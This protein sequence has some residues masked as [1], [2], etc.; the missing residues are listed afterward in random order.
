MTGVQT[1]AL[2]IYQNHE[3]LARLLLQF[4]HK[5]EQATRQIQEALEK[6]D[7]RTAGKLCHTIK[8]VAGNLGATALYQASADLHLSIKYGSAKEQGKK[9]D[10]FATVLSRTMEGISVLEDPDMMPGETTGP[11]G[12]LVTE[13]DIEEWLK[14]AVGLNRLLEENDAG[15]LTA[16]HN[17]CQ[18]VTGIKQIRP[19]SKKVLSLVEEYDFDGAR[20]E[21]T[22]LTQAL[23]HL[24]E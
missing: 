18:R 23:E 2:P 9:L 13:T 1:C 5:Y 12:P 16:A 14:L 22:S 7:I 21:L 4:K 10:E 24:Q 8:G 20:D 17:L 3:L 6:N 15:A 19:V 11:S